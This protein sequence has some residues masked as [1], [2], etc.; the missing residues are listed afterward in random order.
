MNVEESTLATPSSGDSSRVYQE[1][2]GEALEILSLPT[3][4]E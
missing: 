3:A 2:A 1:R 4:R